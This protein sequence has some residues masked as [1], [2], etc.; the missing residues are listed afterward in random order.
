MANRMP[1]GKDSMWGSPDKIVLPGKPFSLDFV[2]VPAASIDG[3]LLDADGKPIAGKGVW[4]AGK[5]LPPSSSVLR[6]GKSDGQ[7][8][9]RFED[10]P[11]GYA[12]WV[13]VDRVM[14][15][16]VR[17]PPLTFSRPTRYKIR[18]QLA[19]D[20]SS[21]LD[22]LKVLSVQDIEGKEVGNAVIGDDPMVRPPLPPELQAKGREILTKM[23][24]ANRYWLDRP[25]PEVRSYRYD[26]KRGEKESKTYEVAENGR[27]AGVVQRGI[28]YV[29]VLYGLTTDSK[30]VVF[31]QIDVQPD[32]MTLTFTLAGG[33]SVSAGNGVLGTWS[34]FFSTTV[35]EGTMIVDPKTYTVQEFHC[36]EYRET[37]SDW[38]EIRPN[39][40][41]PLRVRVSSGHMS[42]DFRFRVYEPGLWLFA[43]SQREGST[44]IAQVDNVIVNGEPG[45]VI[46]APGN[47]L[48]R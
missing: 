41:V 8:R 15:R 40:F 16:D 39:H 30:S 24:E 5:E 44:P 25:P 45:K 29:S 17:T 35:S 21:G 14:R 13:S 33:T 20:A 38:V 31:R 46:H 22:L 6:A 7:G 26:F 3:E 28:S 23:A 27:A 32:K 37:S 2:L 42:F 47:V 34:G 9:F 18:L 11:P 1:S 36:G 19:R 10:V 43:W 48:P 12:W 4:I